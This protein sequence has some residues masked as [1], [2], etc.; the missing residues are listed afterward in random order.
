MPRV[1][2]EITQSSSKPIASREPKLVRVPGTPFV[3][4]EDGVVHLPEALLK[5]LLDNAGR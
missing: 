5:A 3:V 2:K 4:G 1:S